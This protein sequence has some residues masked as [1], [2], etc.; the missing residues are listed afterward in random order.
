MPDKLIIILELGD[1][2]GT[3]S[4]SSAKTEAEA[5]IRPIGCN[6]AGTNNAA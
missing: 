4:S 5:R 6:L 3:Q 1:S 2:C